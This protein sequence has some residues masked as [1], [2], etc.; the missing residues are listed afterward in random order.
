MK[1]LC[2]YMRGFCTWEFD[3]SLSPPPSPVDPN[4]RMDGR[5]SEYLFQF[6]LY[7]FL[8]SKRFNTVKSQM[9]VI[10]FK[11]MQ[12][13][14]PGAAPGYGLIDVWRWNTKRHVGRCWEF[15]TCT[16]SP[17]GFVL[18]DGSF[19]VHV[20]SSLTVKSVLMFTSGLRLNVF[21]SHFS[22]HNIYTWKTMGDLMHFNR[23]WKGFCLNVRSIR[24]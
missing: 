13:L 3:L 7:L 15:G 16:L 9:C 2:L 1:L 5:I 4:N 21:N 8:L 22:V 12:F 6:V 24:Y 14:Y 10:W 17:C 11:T 19:V 23:R 20:C 18:R